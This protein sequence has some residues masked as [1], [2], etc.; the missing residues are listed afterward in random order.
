MSVRV[1]STKSASNYSLID[2]V[3]SFLSK[4]KNE[5]EVLP[6]AVVLWNGYKLRETLGVLHSSKIERNRV[7]LS[8]AN[9]RA[10]APLL[11]DDPSLIERV[12]RRH[13]EAAEE[14]IQRCYFASVIY[15]A[16]IF[17]FS[18]VFLP[19]GPRFTLERSLDVVAYSSTACKFGTTTDPTQLRYRQVP[20]NKD[21]AYA[22]A[23]T[24]TYVVCA[25]GSLVELMENFEYIEKSH[26]A[27][28]TAT[29]LAVAGFA[30]DLI[31]NLLQWAGIFAHRE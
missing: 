14:A 24:T 22:W 31:D 26:P 8:G 4:A 2:S 7:I 12:N 1:K 27:Y 25:I 21:V 19:P 18:A 6:V 15:G 20:T 16:R 13:L 17:R 28:Q 30:S 11:L 3:I 10:A 9:R 5:W 29:T 23:K